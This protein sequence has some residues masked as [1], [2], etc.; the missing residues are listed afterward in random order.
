MKVR[1]H[2]TMAWAMAVMLLV[3]SPAALGQDTAGGVGGELDLL[4][5]PAQM[6]RIEA[7]VDRALEYLASQ[8]RPDGSW[9]SWIG[10]NN[11][12]NAFCLLAFLGRGHVPGRGPYKL[13]ID[14]AVRHIL[15]TQNAKGLYQSPNPSHG[16]MYEHAMATLAII[17]SYGFLPQPAVRQSAQQAI[18]LIAQSQSKLGGWRYQ[19]T[20]TDDDLSVTVMQ[21]VAL[22]AA[23]NARLDVPQKTVDGAL[24]YVKACAH[25]GGGFG[26]KPAGGPGPARSAAGVLSMQLLGA[27]DDPAVTKGL[28]YLA[29]VDMNPA[30]EHFFYMAY[31]AMQAHF[32]A[33]GAYWA[34]WH[35][36]ARKWLLENQTPEGY[37][38]GFGD[39]KYNGQAFCYSTAMACMCLQVYMHYLPAYQR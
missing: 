30:S 17:E 1:L 11:A 22:R 15:A 5:D 38:P 21:V 24:A 28:D 33:G 25:P 2:R 14:R 6:A 3:S 26:Y 39:Q 16:P 9:P 31:Y 13:V 23:M 32:Q 19:P 29:K 37:W 8:Q 12:V 7:S 20:P 4:V 34:R 27:F 18:D 36:K 10:D 35:P